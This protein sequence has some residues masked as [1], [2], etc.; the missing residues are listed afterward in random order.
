V[1]NADLRE[2]KDPSSG[3]NRYVKPI[4]SA[5]FLAG[6]AAALW[7]LPV[8]QYLVFVLEW[9]QSIGAW[10][11]IFVAVFYVAAAVLFLPGSVL[12]LGAGFLFGVPVGLLSAWIGATLGACAAFLVGRTVAREWIARK[13]AR[14]PKFLAVD[15]AVGREG[16]KIVLLLRLSPVFPFNFLNYALGL[17]KVPFKQYA[18]ASAIGML[19]GGLMYTYFGSAARSLADVAAGKV[20][21]G[22][23][24]GQL[25]FWIGLAA[26][27]LVT[28]FVTRL[29]RR[30]LE[31]TQP[32]AGVPESST[33]K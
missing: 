11:P 8:K 18:L 21:G 30:S 1:E 5:V 13:V 22:G 32:R 19:P 10:G 27:I 9:T 23:I 31:A 3:S 20:E 4:I 12:T 14:N 2:S 33:E 25:F 26:T 16:F 7:V 24:A 29:A 17:T 6:L 15:E 28:V